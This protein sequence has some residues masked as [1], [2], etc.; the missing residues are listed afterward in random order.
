VVVIVVALGAVFH[1][2]IDRQMRDWKLLPEPE[3]LT[4]LYFT[5]PNSLPKQYAPGQTQTVRFTTHN[6][7]YQTTAYQYHI[8]ETSQ[9]NNQS[10]TLASGSFT[11]P[12]NAYKQETVN[13]STVDLGQHVKVEVNLMNVNESIDYLLGKVGA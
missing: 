6:L 4:E 10:Q 11:L 1:S 9:A 12:Q 13:I 7:E 3:R 5:Q 2:A 8:V